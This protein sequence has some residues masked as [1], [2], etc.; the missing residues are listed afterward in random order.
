[1]KIMHRTLIKQEDQKADLQIRLVGN[2]S[3][4]RAAL[5]VIANIFDLYSS[6]RVV[7]S[8]ET[9]YTAMLILRKKA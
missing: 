5:T 6:G 3:D 1:M 9:R 7:K 8:D 2:E 4:V